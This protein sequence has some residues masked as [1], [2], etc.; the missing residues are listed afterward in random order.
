MPG[1]LK[2]KFLAASILIAASVAFPQGDPG[3]WISRGA[4]PN[5]RGEIG[6]AVLGNKIYILGGIGGSTG[7]YREAYAY[8]PAE[9]SWQEVAA[10]PVGLHHPNVGAFD[11]K[12]YVLGGC[13]HGPLGGS[14]P[15]GSPWIGSRHSL[16]Y[17]PG[18][19]RWDRIKPIP[20]STAA[21]GVAVVGGRLFVIGGVDTNG[22]VLNRVQEFDP[23]TDTWR[24]R[25]PMPTARE[26][27]GIAVLDSL[28][29]V[30]AGR[31]RG[32][33][34]ISVT[35]FEVFSPARNAWDTLPN[36]PTSRSGLAFVA[37][38]ERLYAMGGEWPGMRDVN[39]EY[40][41][42]GKT[43]RSVEK[44][45]AARHG[46]V[47]LNYNDSI[48]ALGAR[49]VVEVFLPPSI[50]NGILRPSPASITVWPD[51]S[52]DALGRQATPG[53]SPAFESGIV[54]P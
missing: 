50:P 17:D 37:A 39:E 22:I 33:G 36:L 9:N 6:G 3:R 47:A 10:M 31:L 34:G 48:Y 38:R 19:N 25:A 46:F 16:V 23:A 24:E 54:A 11:G 7:G 32:T 21:G 8:S 15:N 1:F 42:K 29:Y 51:L 41:P 2:K 4:T 28:I 27:I 12:L 5:A 13:D 40:D 35:N 26:H 20:H 44:M 14:A 52:V 30:V 43:W 49:N 45:P 18:L 53:I